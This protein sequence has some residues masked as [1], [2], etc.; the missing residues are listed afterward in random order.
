MDQNPANILIAH[1]GDQQ[2]SLENTLSAFNAAAV[3]GARYIECDIQFTKDFIPVVL[4]N[5]CLKRVEL[6]Y[7][8]KVHELT[9]T[10][11]IHKTAPCYS[12]LTFGEL[13]LWLSEQPTITLFSEIKPSILRRKSATFA[14]KLIANLIP[15]K[16]RRQVI[17]ISQSAKL[18]EA[19]SEMFGNRIGWVAEHPR[20]PEAMFEYIFLP[21]HRYL[22][23]I[24]WRERGITTAIYTINRADEAASLHE[25]GIDL[26]ETDHFARLRYELQQ[27]PDP[28][29]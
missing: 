27:L 26:I 15:E 16:I 7:T 3:A 6:G 2:Y 29:H 18:V 25:S 17:P 12:M 8:V 20:K 11:L 14:A 23:A 4:H 1:R 19:C 21:K 10:E 13:L 9:L 22:E 28:A 24:Q 5:N